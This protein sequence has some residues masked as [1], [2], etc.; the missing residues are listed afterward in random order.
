MVDYT[1]SALDFSRSENFFIFLYNFLVEKVVVQ[2]NST[3]KF[4]ATVIWREREY[5]E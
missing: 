3:F 5:S 1:Y 4:D 2:L